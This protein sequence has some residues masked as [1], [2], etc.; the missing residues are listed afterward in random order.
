MLQ[1]TNLKHLVLRIKQDEKFLVDHPENAE[2]IR[3][4]MNRQKEYVIQC[5]MKNENNPLLEKIQ[6]K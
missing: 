1:K 6:M 4:H 2:M 3:E 5:V